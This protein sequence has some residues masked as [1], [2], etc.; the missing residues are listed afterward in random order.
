MLNDHHH[1]IKTKYIRIAN[2]SRVLLFV[3]LFLEYIEQR[4]CKKKTCPNAT[5]AAAAAI[6]T[7]M[8]KY[9]P[10]FYSLDCP[11]PLVH[12]QILLTPPSL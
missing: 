7:K 9:S 12:T 3:V 4:I 10:L 11:M 8:N 2:C 5:A 1:C 6:K